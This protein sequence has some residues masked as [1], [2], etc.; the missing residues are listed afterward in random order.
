MTLQMGILCLALLGLSSALVCPDGGMC[1]DRN[2]CCKNTL[3][4]YGC[5]PL[6][7]AECCS[8]HLHCCYEGTVCDLVHAKCVNKT[9]SLPWMRRV[10]TKQALLG[11]Q[12]TLGERVKAV[13]CPDEESECP[14]DTTC[15]QLLDG[16]WGCC[17]LPKAVCCED[18]LHCCPGGTKCDLAHSKCLSASMESFP[19]LQKLPAR[20]RENNPV[21]CPGGK[22]SCPESFTCCLL[23]SGDY[24]CC[25]YTEA[26]CC[27]DHIHCCPSDTICDLEH[28]ICKSGDT[29]VPLLKKI[30]AVPNDVDCPDKKSA[31]PDETTCCQMTNGTYGCCPMPNAVCCSDHAHCCPE[32]TECDLSHS[33]CVSARGENTMTPKISAAATELVAIQSKVGEVPCDD[34][35]ACADGNTCCKSPVGKWACC[36]L[37]EAVCCEDHLHCCP[38]GTTCNLEASTCDDPSGGTVMP[39]LGKVP[40]FPLLT[41]N[42]KCD[43]TTSCP[44]KST[45]CKT[46]SG[47]WPCCPLPQAVCCDDHVHCCPHSTVCNLEAE[48]CDDPSGFLPSLRW[49]EKVLALT[50]EVE[51]EKCD[52]QTMCPGGTT[53]CNKGSEQWACCPLPQAVC[54]NDHEHCCPKGYKCNMAEQ[55]CDKPGDLSLPWLQKIPAL[56]KEPSRAVSSPALPARN[57]CDAQTSCPRDTTCCFMEKTH[58]WGCCPLPNAVCC[59]D[60]NH[61]CPSGHTCEAQRSSCSKGPHVAIPWFSKLSA[62]TEP[63]A[64]TDVKC[65]DKSSCAAGTTCCKLQTGEWGCCPLVKAVC[66]ADHEHCCPQ[67]YACNMQTGTCEKKDHDALILS[68]PQSEVVQSEPRDPE[69]DAD[70]PCDGTGEFHCPEQDTCCKVSATEWACCPSPRAVCCSDSKHCCPAGYS[71]D[72]KAGGC[73]LHPQLTWDTLIGENRKKDFVRHGL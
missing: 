37:P 4:G 41:D 42:S 22:S 32:G 10:P 20:R 34:Y 16:S 50:A 1:E 13:I 31:C 40:A 23:T 58:K 47:G 21:T 27:S 53:C 70:V 73:S 54:C 19:M 5:C 6:P 15:C 3:G 46:E 28:G 8:D 2:T 49:V 26:M 25:P 60:G 61:C 67:G 66:C 55:T 65:D 57:M 64:V 51:D 11:P 63:G 48:S 38:H 44:G 45:C 33:T 7:R 12:V 35:V 56:Q 14:D 59:S 29:S 39:W 69:D 9:V 72:L 43:K 71:C 24:G 62:L 30:A 36:P 18:K 68:L 17:P 52:K